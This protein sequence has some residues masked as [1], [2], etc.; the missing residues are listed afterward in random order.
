MPPQSPT[1]TLSFLVVCPAV[2]PCWHEGCTGSF[3]FLSQA[4]SHGPHVPCG[5]DHIFSLASSLPCYC[6]VVCVLLGCW[7]RRG[8]QD[9]SLETETSTIG[10]VSQCVAKRLEVDWETDQLEVG[11]VSRSL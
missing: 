6:W 9:L 11:K 1:A 4:L 10:K 7:W 5:L 8:G 3:P 2:E